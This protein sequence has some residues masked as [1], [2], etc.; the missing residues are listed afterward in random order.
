MSGDPHSLLA[1]KE[2]DKEKASWVLFLREELMGR[3]VKS[4]ETDKRTKDGIGY[5]F[6]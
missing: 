5:S 4:E 2:Q 3:G 6:E 1:R